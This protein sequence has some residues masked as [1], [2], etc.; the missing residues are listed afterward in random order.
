MVVLRG[1]TH[2]DK[3]EEKRSARAGTY[4]G[5]RDVEDCLLK[6]GLLE[7]D[8]VH[9]HHHHHFNVHFLSR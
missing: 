2:I 7:E 1:G 4:R 5:M 6:E 9:H 3:N 8:L